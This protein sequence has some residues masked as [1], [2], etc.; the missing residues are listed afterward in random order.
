MTYNYYDFI[1]IIL[2]M[3]VVA[4]NDAAVANTLAG[5]YIAPHKGTSPY[6][7]H[8]LLDKDLGLLLNN[9]PTRNFKPDLTFKTKN[10]KKIQSHMRVRYPKNTDIFFQR[11]P[12]D[13]L[14]ITRR[15]VS[16]DERFLHE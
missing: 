13:T 15:E 8:C 6:F 1:A 12:P 14:K 2:M 10:P 4:M 9:C 3:N 5:K 16:F 7:G 11:P